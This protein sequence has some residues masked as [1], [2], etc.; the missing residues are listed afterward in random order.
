MTLR[1]FIIAAVVLV[2]LGNLGIYFYSQWDLRQF[3]KEIAVRP[4]LFQ[5][6]GDVQENEKVSAPPP[7]P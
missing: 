7:E 1:R 5:D 4:H 3:K 2:I 6:G